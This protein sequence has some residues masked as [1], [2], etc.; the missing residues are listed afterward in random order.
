MT[1][2]SKKRRQSHR[3]A[4]HGKQTDSWCCT[5]PGAKKRFPV[6]SNYLPYCQREVERGEI[7]K[8]RSSA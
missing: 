7:R 6:G 5:Q 2:K 8:R 4:W 3:S 1:R